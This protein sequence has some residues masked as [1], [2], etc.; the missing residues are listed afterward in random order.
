MSELKVGSLCRENQ[1]HTCE[2]FEAMGHKTIMSDPET[3]DGYVHTLGHGVGLNTHESPFFRET[4]SDDD[5]LDP[6]VVVTIE[7]GLYYPQ[8]KMGIRLEDTVWVRP[9]GKMEVMVEYPKDLILQM[10]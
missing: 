8:R 3:M 5:R 7:P 6:N 1:I 10:K 2:L 9:D 4:S